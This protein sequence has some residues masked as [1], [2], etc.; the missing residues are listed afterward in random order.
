MDRGVGPSKIDEQLKKTFTENPEAAY[1][2]QMELIRIL[3]S[4]VS[5]QDFNFQHSYE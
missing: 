2:I 3:L 5:T 4:R 1:Q